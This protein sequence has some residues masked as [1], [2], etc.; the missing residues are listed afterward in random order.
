MKVGSRSAVTVSTTTNTC[1][2]MNIQASEVRAGDLICPWTLR[3]WRLEWSIYLVLSVDPSEQ[4]V[5]IILQ[6][7]DDK[8]EL[9]DMN[10]HAHWEVVLFCRR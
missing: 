2:L 5:H 9:S 6:T 7:L 4:D 3:Y 1:G 8:C 10:M